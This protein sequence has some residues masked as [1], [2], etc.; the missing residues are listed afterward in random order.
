MALSDP[1]DLAY[2]ASFG[3]P[4]RALSCRTRTFARRA[5]PRRDAGP[6]DVLASHAE[7]GLSH[8]G[9]RSATRFSIRNA[10]TQESSEPRN[11]AVHLQHSKLVCETTNWESK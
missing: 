6:T 4:S 9:R 1:S 7:A 2:H 11:D 10:I 3:A 8:V 5:H